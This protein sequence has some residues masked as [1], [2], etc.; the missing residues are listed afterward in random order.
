MALYGDNILE[1]DL[2][3]DKLYTKIRAMTIE[4]FL[5]TGYT[6]E[7][8][9]QEDIAKKFVQ[10][11]SR[12]Q[13]YIRNKVY[14]SKYDYAVIDGFNT[15]NKELIKCIDVP[16]N[17]KEIVFVSDGYRKPFSTL[18]EFRRIFKIYKSSRSTLL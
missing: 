1:N 14:N 6:E 4:Y 11:L 7:E 16:S 17:V 13:P 3:C 9:L 2:E 5:E 15:P 8:L 12:R 10:N 18:K